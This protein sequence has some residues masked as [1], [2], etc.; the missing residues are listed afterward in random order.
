[1]VTRKAFIT[2]TPWTLPVPS[3]RLD[4]AYKA[5]G[6]KMPESVQEGSVS[7]KQTTAKQRYDRQISHAIAPPLVSTECILEKEAIICTCEYITWLHT[8]QTP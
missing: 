4:K 6:L 1:M 5:Y 2:F 7:L 8:C 3:G